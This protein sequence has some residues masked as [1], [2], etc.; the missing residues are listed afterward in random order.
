MIEFG[1]PAALWTGLAIGLP[2]LAHMAYRRITQKHAFPSLRFITPSQIPELGRKT[3]TD[4]P[5]LLLRIL[6]F[7]TIM[8][9]LADPYWSRSAKP[10]NSSNE[11]ELIIAIDISPSMGGWNGLKEAKVIAADIISNSE[12]KIGLVTFGKKI[13]NEW[14]VGTERKSLLESLEKISHGWGR[15]DAQI[16]ADRV[17]RLFGENTP[18]KKLRDY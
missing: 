13:E 17:G 3:P 5:L 9:L 16:L 1:Q 15:G 4:L 2:I 11:K 10:E 12:E 8:L 6:L 7:I 18:Q 14:P